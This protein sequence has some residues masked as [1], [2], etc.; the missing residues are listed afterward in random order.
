MRIV[1]LAE[2]L[3]LPEGTVFAKYAPCYFGD[4]CIKDESLTDIN[5]FY[6]TNVLANFDNCEDSG[7]W[8]D[9]LDTMATGGVGVPIAFDVIMRD[10]IFDLGQQFA[11]FERVDVE[12]LIG[13]LADSIKYPLDAKRIRW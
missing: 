12:R 13:K 11:V 4:L 9:I 1:G 7:E 10:G 8:F 3:S 2:F 5:D 6:Y